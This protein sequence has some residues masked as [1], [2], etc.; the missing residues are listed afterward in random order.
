MKLKALDQI[1]VSSVSADS[2]RPGQEFTVSKAQGDELLK[3]HPKIFQKVSDEEPAAKA[4]IAP[5]GEAL[6]APANKADNR[7]KNK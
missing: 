5:I 1:S 4:E 7:R 6:N 3:A 2:L